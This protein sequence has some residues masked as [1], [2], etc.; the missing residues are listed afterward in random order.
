MVPSIQEH[1]SGSRHDQ[2]NP[3]GCL[4]KVGSAQK[5]KTDECQDELR[6]PAL[7]VS[8]RVKDAYVRAVVARSPRQASCLRHF[9]AYRRGAGEF[10]DSKGILSFV[11]NV[12]TIRE[13]GFPGPSSVVFH[14]GP[15]HH[16]MPRWPAPGV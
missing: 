10:C 15:R 7:S 3:V 11:L 9:R 14:G 8:L 4:G 2:F 13:A 6:W 16:E 5:Q 12:W 1:V